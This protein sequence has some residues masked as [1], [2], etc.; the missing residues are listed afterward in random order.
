MVDQYE[1]RNT[2]ISDLG[3]IFELFGHSI[4]YQEKHGY[5]VWKNYDKNAIVKDIENKNQYKVIVDSKTAIVFSVCYT[6]KVIWRESD[7]EDSIY[8]HRIVV[9]PEFK[10]RKLFGTIVDWAIK[11]CKKKGL[12]NIRMD[13]WAVNPTIVNYYKGFGFNF[14]ENYTTPDSAELPVHN[15]NLALTLLEYKIEEDNDQQRLVV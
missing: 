6:D 11:H 14:V 8:L 2:E 3:L 13:T 15:R 5:P 9:N 1:V 10:G 4:E 12:K 7:K